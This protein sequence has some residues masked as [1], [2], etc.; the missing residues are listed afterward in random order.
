MPTAASLPPGADLFPGYFR[1][2]AVHLDFLIPL[3]SSGSEGAAPLPVV[4]IS[5]GVRVVIL[6]SGGVGNTHLDS[7]P[8]ETRCDTFAPL[9]VVRI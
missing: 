2:G 9:Q 8:A 7:L 4:P 3:S 1:L 6:K 5:L